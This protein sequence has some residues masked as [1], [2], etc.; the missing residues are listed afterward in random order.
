MKFRKTKSRPNSRETGSF[1]KGND[2]LFPPAAEHRRKARDAQQGS[3]TRLGDRIPGHEL[4]RGKAEGTG[5]RKDLELV[6]RRDVADIEE[7]HVQ[8]VVGRG[9]RVLGG[10]ACDLPETDARRGKSKI[11]ELNT[12]TINIF[13]C[14]YRWMLPGLNCILLS[15]KSK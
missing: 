15:R 6:A 7:D 5:I 1:E 14:R 2:R 10:R 3:R 8:S 4:V 13:F 11:I 12:V 9:H